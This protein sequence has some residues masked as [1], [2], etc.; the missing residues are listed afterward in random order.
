MKTP[1]LLFTITAIFILSCNTTHDLDLDLEQIYPVEDK[2]IYD[3]NPYY[4]LGDLY[5]SL[6]TTKK[7]QEDVELST[8]YKQLNATLLSNSIQILESKS[9]VSFTETKHELFLGEVS[10]SE[11]I[12]NS[13]LSEIA[14]TSLYGFTQ[15]LVEYNGKN[16]D[17]VLQQINSYELETVNNDSLNS[18]DK[19][20]ILTFIVLVK[21]TDDMQD[22]LI[23]SLDEEEDE[24]EE[25]EDLDWTISIIN[26][27]SYLGIALSETTEEMAQQ[28]FSN[29]KR[30]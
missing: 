7:P 26:M 5:Q 27:H 14:K 16:L 12:D 9:K 23:L 11:L 8:I 25:E 6:L 28:L 18:Y 22:P 21:S 1:K 20:V 30:L 2:G 17:W 24:E 10:L 13:L 29:L 19:Q 4:P 15:D 3:T